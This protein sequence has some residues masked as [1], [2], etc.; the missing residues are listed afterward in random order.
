MPTPTEE[1]LTK[2]TL[3]LFT[4]DVEWLRSWHPNDYTVEIRRIVQAYV[5][6][7]QSLE[8]WDKENV[9]G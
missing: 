7:K 4:K 6:K 2:V 9:D 5:V 1:P 3:N 8:D